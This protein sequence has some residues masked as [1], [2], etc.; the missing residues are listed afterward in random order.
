MVGETANVG[1]VQ[2]NE[3]QVV[4]VVD[5]D[6]TFC[7]TDTLH[8]ALLASIVKRPFEMFRWPGWLREGRAGFKARV[9][10]KAVMDAEDLPFNAAV[11]E[12]IRTAREAGRKTALVSAADHRQV[13]AIAEAT[14]LFDEAYGTAEGRNLKGDEKTAFLNAHYG[15]GMF[16][17]IGDSEADLSVWNAARRAITVQASPKLRQMAEAANAQV[18]H[19]DPPRNTRLAMLKALR[20]HQWSKNLLLFLP[21]FAAHDMSNVVSVI[22]GFLAFCL[23][24]SAVYVMNDLLDLASD[25]A[26]PRKRKRP[27]AAGDLS[28]ATGLAMAAVLLVVAF[29]FGILT[30]Q[31]MFLVVLSLYL[32]TTFL[33]SLYLKRKLVVDVLTLAGLYTVRILAGGA[34]A[35]VIFSPWMLGFS[36]FLF[37][38]LAAVKRQAELVDLEKSG[39]KSVG[40]AYEI[41]DLPV[42]RAMAMSAGHAA[43]LVLA[44]YISSDDVQRLYEQPAYL[45]LVCPLL[46][47]WTTRMLMKT[48]RGAMTDDPIVFAITDRV[49][50]AVGLACGVVVLAAAL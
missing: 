28:A 32:V 24:A 49:S 17:Y 35:A 47:Y 43:V 14:G 20:P 9:A 19:I 44:L 38:S 46:L 25:R 26:H 23:T 37:L 6:G 13:T 10:D 27:F 36:M 12:T 31:P 2:Q 33:Y 1:E 15:P 18:S 29:L 30:G 11:L 7:R 40:R 45:W 4:L 42:I 41:D 50:Q 22:L 8:E 39:R 16:D 5:L 34:A 21:M 48:H 3:N